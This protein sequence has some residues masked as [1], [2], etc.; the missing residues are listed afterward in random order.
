MLGLAIASK[1]SHSLMNSHG[2]G[3]WNQYSLAAAQFAP[4]RQRS[5]P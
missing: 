4:Q 3:A 2:N 5:S 1:R